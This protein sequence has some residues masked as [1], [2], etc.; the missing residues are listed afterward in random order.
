MQLGRQATDLRCGPSSRLACFLLKTI[1]RAEVKGTSVYLDCLP[2]GRDDAEWP[3]GRLGARGAAGTDCCHGDRSWCGRGDAGYSPISLR[4]LFFW[5]LSIHLSCRS[6][7]FSNGK[8]VD[9]EKLIRRVVKYSSPIFDRNIRT[10]LS[11]HG[12]LHDKSLNK[13]TIFLDLSLTVTV[14]IFYF[15]NKWTF[16][17]I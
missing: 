15:G 4:L 16:T 17:V 5:A 2:I 11:K 14:C 7:R 10:L 1:M 9:K 3:R 13:R 12:N 6:N 8:S